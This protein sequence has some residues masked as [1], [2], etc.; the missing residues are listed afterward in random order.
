MCRAIYL[1]LIGLFYI[2]SDWMLEQYSLSIVAEEGKSM[3]VA[4][5]WE[6][7]WELWPLFILMLV[8]SSA[9]TF[10]AAGSGDRSKKGQCGC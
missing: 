7:V 1:A 6:I 2:Y 4:L 8:V 9:V 3:V 10:F 5:G